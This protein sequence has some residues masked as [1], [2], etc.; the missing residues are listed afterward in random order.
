MKSTVTAYQNEIQEFCQSIEE[1]NN[2]LVYRLNQLNDQLP[3]MRISHEMFSYSIDL[4]G[5]TVPT[6][7]PEPDLRPR[8]PVRDSSLHPPPQISNNGIAGKYSLPA[9]KTS[10]STTNN[11]LSSTDLLVD[12]DSLLSYLTLKYGS[13]GE[14]ESCLR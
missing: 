1:I 2:Q 9:T 7:S 12:Y 4:I 6:P 10:S 13:P 5:K 11:T 14:R 3:G 8:P